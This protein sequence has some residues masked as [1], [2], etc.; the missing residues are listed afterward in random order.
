[1]VLDREEHGLVAVTR[2]ARTRL[3]PPPVINTQS[4]LTVFAKYDGERGA[5]VV[6]LIVAVGVVDD[7]FQFAR[8]RQE[9][10]NPSIGPA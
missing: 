1:M 5:P 9:G 2:Q 7:K 6:V 10:P 4:Y 3:S 8:L